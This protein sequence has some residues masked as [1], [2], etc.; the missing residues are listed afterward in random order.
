MELKERIVSVP[1]IGDY[2][3]IIEMLVERCLDCKILPSFAVT[4]RTVEIGSKNS[5]DMICTPFK[6]T[7][8]GFIEAVQKGANTLVMLGSGCRLG[9]YDILQKQVLQDLGYDIEMLV[10]FDYLANEQRLFKSLS[11]ANPDL[12][13][14][15]FNHVLGIVVQIV[16]DMDRFGEYMRR[17]MAFEINKG[18]HERLYRTYLK[19]V[20]SAQSTIEAEAIAAR[21]EAQLCRVATDKPRNPIR[22]GIVGEMYAVIEP[23]INCYMEK[24]LLEH[25]VEIIRP[26]DLTRIAAALFTVDEQIERS[27]GYVTY[28]VGSTANDSIAHAYEMIQEGIDGIIHIKPSACSPEITCMTILQNMSRDHNVPITYLTFDTETSEAGLHTRLE[29]FHDMLTMRR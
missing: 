9:L 6:I 15:Q 12:T 7:L 17:N 29:A 23:S 14:E 24:W 10:L 2:H 3:V 8:G 13:L 5:P 27:G 16:I 25:R 1:R 4:R 18:E 22:I 11:E 19:D 26:V 20:H 28:N 21:C